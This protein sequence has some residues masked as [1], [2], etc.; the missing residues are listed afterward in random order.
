MKYR[1][2]K[3]GNPS[4]PAAPKKQYANAVNAGKFTLKSLAKE[5]SGRLSLTRK[6]INGLQQLV[7]HLNEQLCERATIEFT[8]QEYNKDYFK[9]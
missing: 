9:K 8:V 2:V 1:I 3:R 4:N 7:N 6:I 5:V